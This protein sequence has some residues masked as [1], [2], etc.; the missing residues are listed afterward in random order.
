MNFFKIIFIIIFSALSLKSQSLDSER[1]SGHIPAEIER[2]YQRGL[3][4][5]INTQEDNGSWP[6]REGSEP[7]VVGLCIKAILAHGEDAQFGPYSQNIQKALDYIIST[8]NT[9]N[10]MIGESMY[11]HGFALL[12]LAECYGI[13]DHPKLASSL[14]AALAL[15]IASQKNNQKGAW[16]YSPEAL[17]A[18]STVTGCQLVSLYAVQNAG[19][20][21]PDEVFQKAIAYLE[22]CRTD[23]GSYSYTDNRSNARVTL[24]AI[25]GL[26]VALER[27][28]NDP[29]VK[30][31]LQYLKKNINFRDRTYPYYLEYYLSQ[32]LFQ[33][34]DETWKE[35]NIKNTRYLATL[36]RS[37]GSWPGNRSEAFNTSG[38]LLSLALN[39]Q[40]L[41]I[42]EK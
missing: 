24:S 17:D 8:Q 2:M 16:R 6:G 35:W 23:E 20:P 10:G 32:A 12:A 14:E 41:P 40:F 19:I 7:G 18:D 27:K 37:N 31:T 15:T 30:T 5:L 29:R 38:A 13:I 1:S 26:C 42:Y 36:Q 11:N 25:G 21:V 9:E 4:Y 39:Y 28:D 33:L 34:D 22:K 3:K